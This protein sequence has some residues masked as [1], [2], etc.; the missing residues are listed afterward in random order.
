LLGTH[1]VTMDGIGQRTVIRKNCG[2][3]IQRKFE[4]KSG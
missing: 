2:K 1:T 3:V 4:T